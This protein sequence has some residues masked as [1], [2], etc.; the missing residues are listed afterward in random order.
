[1]DNTQA[2]AMQAAPT[3]PVVNGRLLDSKTT[4]AILNKRITVT[5]NHIGSSLRLTIQ[6]TGQFLPQGHKYT[7]GDEAR[8]NKFDRTIYN[9][10]A[11]SADLMKSNKP[12]FTEAMKAESAGDV[13]KS[14]DL[15][16][17]YL[18]AVQLSFSVIE[19]SSRTFSNG[20]DVKARIQLAVSLAGTESL[21]VEDVSY[22]AP[23][24]V[25]ATKFDITDLIEA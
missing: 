23:V 22:I 4:I 6:G 5:R 16:N 7:V 2:P 11:S 18:N 12:L 1:M 3:A 10:R 8:E 17:A 9:L 21:Q 13:N 25:R 19:P 14:H 24:A 15:F 20:D